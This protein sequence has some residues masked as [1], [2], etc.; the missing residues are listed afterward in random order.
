MTILPKKKPPPKEKKTDSSESETEEVKVPSHP[1]H[2]PNVTASNVAPP[3]FIEERQPFS[4]HCF[5]PEEDYYDD[6]SYE[7]EETASPPQRK[8]YGSPVHAAKQREWDSP[9]MSGYNSSE[10]YEPSRRIVYDTEKERMFEQTL[11]KERGFIIKRMESDGACLFRAIADQ[12]YG[13]QEMHSAA[14]N[15]CMDYMVKNM[16]YFSQYI[17]EDFTAYINR[18]RNDHCMGN[19]T[20]MQAMAEM[21]NRTIEV[22]QYD[23]EPINIFHGIY[24]TDNAP[25]RLSYHQNVHYNSVVDPY[26][27]SVG[28]GLGLAGYKP[29]LADRNLLSSVM[30]ESE[31]PLIEKAMLEDKMR[32]SDMETTY[33]AIEEAVAKESYLLWLKE[34]TAQMGEGSKKG[35]SSSSVVCSEGIAASHHTPY[36]V[37]HSTAAVT[38]AGKIVRTGLPSS[39][40]PLP[41][42]TPASK[43]TPTERLSRWSTT[44]GNLSPGRCSPSNSPRDSPDSIH[45]HCRESRS[46]PC[47]RSSSVSSGFRPI[48]SA[49]STGS[50]I[51]G[52]SSS[53]KRKDSYSSKGTH[54]RHSPYPPGVGKRNRT[55]DKSNH[56]TPASSPT[57]L[58]GRSSLER[59][60]SNQVSK[61]GLRAEATLPSPPGTSATGVQEVDLMTRYPFEYSSFMDL[62]P[63]ALGLEEWEDDTILAAVLAASQ[64]E[65]I[66]KLKQS[67]DN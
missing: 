28:V 66:D 47:S 18:K 42:L 7:A 64:Q 33:D 43:V 5:P 46:W 6:M 34:Q 9:D 19:H 13:D 60:S 48:S 16:D 50:L 22:Y 30:L 44:R 36:L 37:P 2:P 25:I 56:T 23:S 53:S 8:Q 4:S 49:H 57:V 31:K 38:S 40:A 45:H 3:P 15:L 58:P 67:K 32:L 51:K 26:E 29:G 52:K 55:G 62:P 35:E 63:S 21:F 61:E 27:P 17:T 11:K 59:E 20:E 24:K 14:R 1:P 12:V 65:Y 39:S 54:A 10:E 41:V